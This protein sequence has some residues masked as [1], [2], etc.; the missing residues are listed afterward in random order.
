MSG[1]PWTGKDPVTYKIE[2]TEQMGNGTGGASGPGAILLN[3]SKPPLPAQ[4]LTVSNR[5]AE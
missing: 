3:A 2:G 4:A 5:L 1:L